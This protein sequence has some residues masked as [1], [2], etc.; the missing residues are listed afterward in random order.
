MVKYGQVDLR[1]GPAADDGQDGT[2]RRKS[3][4]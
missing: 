1:V 2:V 3:A 4:K